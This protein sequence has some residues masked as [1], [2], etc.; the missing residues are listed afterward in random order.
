MLI[1]FWVE[2]YRCFGKRLELDLTDKKNYRFGV[3]CVRGDFLD[4][5]V[6]IGSNNAGKTSLGFAM[7]DIVCT[8]GGFSKDIGQKNVECFLNKDTEAEVATFHYELSHRGSIVTYEYSK[9]SPDD[10]VAESLMLD[11]HLVYRY[12]LRDGKGLEYD[13]DRLRIRSIPIIGKDRSLIMRIT[14]SSF[15]DPD[16]A[17]G[18]VIS[19]ATHSL[20]YMA[21]WKMDVHI[22]LIDEEDNT[23]RYLVRNGLVPEF[24]GF[25][26]DQCMVDI[27]LLSC[28][29]NL[30]VKK[31]HG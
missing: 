4:K 6:V 27:D 25:L 2:G 12:D 16:S 14:E 10:M 22:G 3:E 17:V 21:M 13:P 18:V 20:Y 24:Q 29:G 23:E 9:S 8:A 31:S 26:R 15:V 5:M 11:R 1:R 19:F 30:L 7:T 28:E